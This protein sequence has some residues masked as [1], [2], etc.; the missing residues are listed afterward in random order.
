M[1]TSPA[2]DAD[3][4]LWLDHRLPA[5]AEG[6]AQLVRFNAVAPAEAPA[7]AWLRTYFG[8]RASIRVES[9]HP[10]LP[11]H[12]DANHNAYLGRA[13]R[14][15]LSVSWPGSAVRPRLLFSAHVDVVP[16]GSGF[17]EAF[18]PHWDGDRLVGRG[19]ADTQG[20]IIMLAA[21]LDFLRM[22]DR[23][24]PPVTLDLVVEEEIG[25]NGALSTLLHG[26]QADGVVVLEPTDLE[27]FH[28][29][30][31]CLEFTATVTGRAGHMGG[32]GISAILGAADLINQLRALQQR[33]IAEVSADP[34][35]RGYPRPVQVNVGTIHG[36]EWHGSLAETCT[37]G[38]SLGFHPTLD[39]AAARDLLESLPRLLDEPWLRDHIAFS[40]PGIHNGAYIGD[41][42]SWLAHG[43]RAAVRATGAAPAERRAWCVSCDARLY[44]DHL[45][46]PVVVF[47][48][49]SL[50][51]AHSSYE[52]LELGQWRRGVRALVRLLT[53]AGVRTW[54][55]E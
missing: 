48:A 31:G 45:R 23:S 54:S 34:A 24:H 2:I 39:V 40:Y 36:G 50:D 29:H 16:A 46:V 33:M 35:F 9:F 20:N 22:H 11:Q 44:H 4:D 7:L 30:R 15:T 37:V 13:G 28:G 12:P 32:S 3:L 8:R 53:E 38:G 6:I 10:D 43:L 51:Q 47:G 49:G 41:P 21:A 17:P 1:S 5:Y 42:D 14:E 25:G 18:Q 55:A 52:Y 19:T 27:V 26:R